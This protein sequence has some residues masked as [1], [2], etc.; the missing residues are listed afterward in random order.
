MALAKV[1]TSGTY[2]FKVFLSLVWA[3]PVG[4]IGIVLCVTVIGIPLG[5]PLIMLAAWPLAQTQR[6]RIEEKVN[7]EFR[8]RPMDN[9]NVVPWLTDDDE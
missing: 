3:I 2:V 8:P 1:P 7:W 5:V 6:T 9:E 4:F